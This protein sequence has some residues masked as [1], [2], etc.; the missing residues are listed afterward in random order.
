MDWFGSG[1]LD[2]LMT[3]DAKVVRFVPKSKSELFLTL[4][5][6]KFLQVGCQVVLARLC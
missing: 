5:F 4:T 6:L 3:L 2:E 1:E